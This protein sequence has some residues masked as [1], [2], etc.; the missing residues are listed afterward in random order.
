MVFRLHKIPYKCRKGV[1]TL[2]TP[3]GICKRH[4]ICFM[5]VCCLTRYYCVIVYCKNNFVKVKIRIMQLIKTIS[6]LIITGMT[7]IPQ[8]GV[9]KNIMLKQKLK[10]LE[11]RS[12]IYSSYTATPP[13]MDG[14][15]DDH[16]WKDI[17]LYTDFRLMNGKVPA[18][19]T[20]FMTCHDEQYLYIAVKAYASVLNPVNNLVTEFRDSVTT[21]DGDV[22][23]DD[24]IEFF[25]AHDGMDG[26][27]HIIAN[28]HTTFER[29]VTALGGDTT[30]NPELKLGT[31]KSFAKSHHNKDAYYVIELALPLA[32]IGLEYPAVGQLR[33]NVGREEKMNRENSNWPQISSFHDYKNYPT[34]VLGKMMLGGVIHEELEKVSPDG[35]IL[36]Y[37]ITSIP[38]SSLKIFTECMVSQT[39][40]LVSEMDV[41]KGANKL[42]IQSGPANFI[43][44]SGLYDGETIL[45][46]S[47]VRSYGMGVSSGSI[48]LYADSKQPLELT[49]NGQAV[50]R[51]GSNPVYE[52]SLVDGINRVE[53]TANG[54]VELKLPWEKQTGVWNTVDEVSVTNQNGKWVSDSYPVTLS[55]I[56]LNNHSRFFPHISSDDPLQISLGVPQPF[57][58]LVNGVEKQD[59]SNYKFNLELPTVLE[60][61]GASG[62]GKRITGRTSCAWKRV[63]TFTR[64]QIDY[65]RYLITYDGNNRKIP[66][67]LDYVSSEKQHIIKN[68]IALVIRPKAGLAEPGKIYHC[69]YYAEANHGEVVE[70]KKS[71]PVKVL[72]PLSGQGP[73]KLISMTWFSYQAL[74]DDDLAKEVFS[75]H[76]DAGFNIAMAQPGKRNVIDTPSMK[77]AIAFHFKS[78][79][80]NP[81]E[82]KKKFK[83]L[84]FIDS[85]GT[86]N[87]YKIPFSY[88]SSHLEVRASFQNEFKK[89]LLKNQ[90]DAADW[91][92][93]F[94]V[95]N[96]FYTSYD[97]Y[98]LNDFK[99]R[100]SITN[101]LTPSIIRT[102]YKEDWAEY[103]NRI[104][105]DVYKAMH[106]VTKELHIK[107]S[108]YSGYP[109]EYTRVSYG[110]DHQLVLPHLDY[111]M[112]GYGRPVGPIKKMRELSVAAGDKPFVFGVCAKP[113]Y[114]YQI[115]SQAWIPPA[116]LLRRVV[117]CG[118]GVMYWGHYPSD[119]RLI[120][121]FN[122]VNRMLYQHEEF[123]VDGKK[124]PPPIKLKDG[125]SIDDVMAYVLGDSLLL[126]LLNTEQ[127]EAHVT[128]ALE[129]HGY[130][131]AEEYYTQQRFKNPAT[132]TLIVPSGG[133]AALRFDK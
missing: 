70:V 22:C 64:D 65:N 69:G 127:Q 19:Q 102:Q 39:K 55:R 49:V 67:Q 54:P 111:V 105:A 30:W 74:D 56:I 10:Q 122:E 89:Y 41:L 26:Y 95:F 84:R 21:R 12:V 71:F 129:E 14:Q 120:Y 60:F 46:R 18:E 53:V 52:L 44:T 3:T 83:S 119:G 62:R 124:I 82:V 61:V 77:Y 72:P 106:E 33:F 6:L 51:S 15:L 1:G 31:S 110:I 78:N 108:M 81:S 11:N 43:Y 47:R 97:E 90:A 94:D 5:I 42:A 35:Q 9:S 91:D 113:Y 73:K 92:F 133:I 126:L 29:H 63:D 20:E 75:A 24:C 27:Y 125:M 4:Y 85:K 115:K 80:F 123:I 79:N 87:A 32:S 58:L 112:M 40:V 28:L 116:L 34:L 25:F 13:S 128:F 132:L 103:M 48:K 98:T 101:E 100:Y 104:T 66:G 93:E 38:D 68:T 59:M 50:S 7:I 36:S 45:Y 76:A 2:I 37:H 86:Y 99:Q 121:S 131:Q 96:G 107:L 8:M 109:S 23:S 118:Y 88:I 57:S 117:D 17:F 16:C 114:L 130:K